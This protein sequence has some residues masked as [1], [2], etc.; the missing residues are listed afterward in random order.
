MENRLRFAIILY[1]FVYIPVCT[2][3]VIF[4]VLVQIGLYNTL[5]YILYYYFI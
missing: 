2:Y 4:E 3:V 1:S 5:F